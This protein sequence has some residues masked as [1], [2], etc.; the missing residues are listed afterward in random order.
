M[1]MPVYLKRKLQNYVIPLFDDRGHPIPQEYWG[2]ILPEVKDGRLLRKRKH[3][4]PNLHDIDPDFGEVYDENKHGEILLAELTIAHI[5]TVQKS[6]LTK[7][8]KKYWRMFSKKGVTTTVKDYECEIDT[9]NAR[10]IRCRNPT[11][12]P[13][14]TRLI[15]KFITKLVELGN[16]EHIYFGE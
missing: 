12:G 16:D 6:V 13:I 3:N 15:E 4:S 10:S 9:D 14:I 11:F 1:K 7:V 8:V 5:T 2:S